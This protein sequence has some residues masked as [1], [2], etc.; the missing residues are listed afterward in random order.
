MPAANKGPGR[1]ASPNEKKRDR[2]RER[3]RERERDREVHDKGRS[4]I[5][6]EYVEGVYKHCV[7]GCVPLHSSVAKCR[8]GPS[9][10]QH[11]SLRP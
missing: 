3:E 4:T 5:L 10:A 2:E 11:A 6:I 8:A 1:S 9:R 7:A